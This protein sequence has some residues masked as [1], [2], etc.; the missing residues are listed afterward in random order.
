[1]QSK[2]VQ[3]SLFVG[4]GGLLIFA[5]TLKVAELT[6]PLS[7][8][9]G[10]MYATGIRALVAGIE[11]CLGLWMISGVFERAAWKAC[12]T[13]LAVFAAFSLAKALN[14][15]E[16]CGC[17]GRV[18]V[19][20]VATLILDL[21]LL[22]AVARCQPTSQVREGESSET[23]ARGLSH[24]SLQ[25]VLPAIL[26]LVIA[27]PSALV[28]SPGTRVVDV[29]GIAA[30]GELVVLRPQEW[31]GQVFPLV[32]Y[33]DTGDVFSEGNWEL[34]LYHNNCPDC[35]KAL[36][37]MVQQS[38]IGVAEQSRQ[39]AIEV[40]P[41]GTAGSVV[42]DRGRVLHRKLSDKYDWFVETP[43]LLSLADGRVVSLRAGKS[44]LVS[45]IE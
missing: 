4:V 5:A 31:L 2:A 44:V 21:G 30:E 9:T 16:S 13:S 39:A 28:L 36:A 17:F 8:K 38:V 24:F 14:G 1:M 23:P 34:L 3:Q 10:W 7:E 32:P 6:N 27:I 45:G 25:R 43:L 15:E 11:G 41:Y 12:V 37:R 20:P 35:Q 18:Q 29:T 26:A 19:S 40:P 42:N 33:I 22:V